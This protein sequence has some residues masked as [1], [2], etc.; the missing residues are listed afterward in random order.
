MSNS[1]T[2]Q[3]K[4]VSVRLP[5]R[6]FE[7]LVRESEIQGTTVAEIA[8]QRIQQAEKQLEIKSLIASLLKHV[9]KENFV[10]TSS[11]A[12]LDAQEKRAALR[13]AEEMLGRKL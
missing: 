5:V 6:D 13:Q 3:K 11:I 4:Q 1:N 7:C 12:G 9:T 2:I 10:V 8:R